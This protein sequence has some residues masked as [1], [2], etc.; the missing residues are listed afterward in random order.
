[1]QI[2][3]WHFPNQPHLSYGICGPQERRVL[4]VL[5]TLGYQKPSPQE[6]LIAIELLLRERSEPPTLTRET[7]TLM[8]LQTQYRIPE[9]GTLGPELEPFGVS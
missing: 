9:N 7:G 3:C 8:R 6:F 5:I 4:L 1:M 2:N